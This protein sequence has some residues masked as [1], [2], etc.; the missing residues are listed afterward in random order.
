MSSEHQ[1]FENLFSSKIENHRDLTL[2][3]V[4][5]I[6]R[7][8]HEQG[9]NGAATVKLLQWIKLKKAAHNDAKTETEEK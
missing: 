4:E 9:I 1:E 7:Y 6:L 8:A 5:D 3:E 2:E